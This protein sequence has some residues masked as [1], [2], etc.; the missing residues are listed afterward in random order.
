MDLDLL[1]S[2]RYGT[3]R[4][5]FALPVAGRPRIERQAYR[6]PSL[7][8]FLAKHASARR[9]AGAVLSRCTFSRFP[10]GFTMV[11]ARL[12]YPRKRVGKTGPQ[13]RF[14]FRTIHVLPRLC[15]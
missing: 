9:G 14:L 10:L 12:G 5:K 4:R 3:V 13:R 8:I 6:E 15:A 2:G 1:S 7:H 11:A